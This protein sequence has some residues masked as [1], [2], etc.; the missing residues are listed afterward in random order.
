MLHNKS[1]QKKL[2]QVKKWKQRKNPIFCLLFQIN[3]K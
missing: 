2:N 1:S 3:S